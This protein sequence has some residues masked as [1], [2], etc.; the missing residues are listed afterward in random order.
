MKILIQSYNTCSQ[1]ESG[2][3]QIKLKNTIS[4]LRDRGI[5]VDLFDKFNTKVIDYDILH[6]FRL[7]AENYDL[8]KYAKS[9]GVKI[10]ISTICPLVNGWK[11]ALYKKM[12][13]LPLTT[14]Y[15]LMMKSLE[16][17]DKIIVESI[18]EKNFLVK[19][20]GAKPNKI[21][22]IT[23]GVNEFNTYSDEI[24][25]ILGK[26]CKY[27]LQVGRFDENKNQLNVIKAL[28]NTNINVVFVGGATNSNKEYYEKCIKE[29]EK[30]ERFYFLGWIE[31]DSAIMKSIYC[32]A[33]M[34]VLPSRYE[35]FGLVAIEAGMAGTK[36]ALSRTLPILE[37]KAFQN[38]ETFDPNNLE[39]MRKKILITFNQKKDKKLKETIKKSF[40]WEKIINDY[41]KC[42]KEV[43]NEEVIIEDI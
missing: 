3:V 10:I 36:L 23:N 34:L 16:L 26:K 15:K 7:D 17:A 32:N 41:I 14:T 20:Y 28:K 38:C 4:L 33:E 40:S 37:Y 12:I 39:E 11:I 35:T 6:I 24:Y 27:V 22:A 43:V 29:A 30:T 42:Y 8:I 19:Y 21:V 31:N 9:M 2:G 25:K 13:K 1:N 5:K 18:A